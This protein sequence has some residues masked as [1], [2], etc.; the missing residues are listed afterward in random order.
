MQV[1]L[2]LFSAV[3]GMHAELARQ[4]PPLEAILKR[5]TD[6]QLPVP[7]TVNRCPEWHDSL[8]SVRTTCSM[9]HTFA[10]DERCIRRNRLRAAVCSG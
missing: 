1:L 4:A 2:V 7:G 10:Q 6:G 8:A 3:Q 5:L 9:L